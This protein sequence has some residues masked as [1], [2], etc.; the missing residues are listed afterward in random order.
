MEYYA[1]IISPLVELKTIDLKNT[2]LK[3]A[4]QQNFAEATPIPSLDQNEETMY[5]VTGKHGRVKAAKEV[6][7]VI[8]ELMDRCYKVFQTLKDRLYS[9]PILKFLVFDQPFILYMDNSKERGYGAA[10]H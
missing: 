5:T 8:P 9:A 6:P 4:K 3:G 7:K 1:E 10:L 2:P